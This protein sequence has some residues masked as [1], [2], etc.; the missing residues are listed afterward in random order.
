MSRQDRRETDQTITPQ[1]LAEA[2]IPANC[3][4]CYCSIKTKTLLPQPVTL[5]LSCI[6]EKGEKKTE[7]AAVFDLIQ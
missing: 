3:Q 2:S 1:Q 6:Q 4:K 7:I 5:T